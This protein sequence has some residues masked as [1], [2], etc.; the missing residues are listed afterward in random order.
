[1]PHD[2]PAQA[3]IQSMQSGSSPAESTRSP[4]C[5]TGC[6]AAVVGLRG[7]VTGVLDGAIPAV[8][9]AGADVVVVAGDAACFAPRA[10]RRLAWWSG[11]W[12]TT[13]PAADERSAIAADRASRGRPNLS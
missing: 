1:M 3:P 8:S 10:R 6:G 11:R 9:G 5:C 7:E 13:T 2:E 4:P 12:A